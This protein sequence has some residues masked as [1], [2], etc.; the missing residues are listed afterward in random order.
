MTSDL[1][2][3]AASAAGQVKITAIKAMQTTNRSGTWIKIE[4]DAGI[5]GYGPC[6][7]P[8]RWHAASSIPS[9]MVACRI[10]A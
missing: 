5:C 10:S 9:T 4:T 2:A 6:H 3:L 1:Q 8:G 7:A